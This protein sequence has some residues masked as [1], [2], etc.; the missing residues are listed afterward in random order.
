M[1]PRE[2]ANS[3]DQLADRWN[4]DTFSRSN[5]IEQ[6][7][8]AVAFAK[9]KRRALDIGCG[10]SGRIIDLLM[11]HG[12][13]AEGLDISPRMIRLAKQRHPNV[14]F[15]H[16]DIRGWNFAR[17]YDLI[18]GWD[19]I[20]HVPL[21]DYEAVLKKILHA[22]APGGVCIFTTAGVDAPTEKVDNFMGP[23]M[24]Y[25]A[26]GIPNT[27]KLLSEAGCSLRH[28]EYDQ[29][30]ELHMYIIAQRAD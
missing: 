10:S 12:F 5:G 6:H 28:L 25:S 1:T 23:P 3:Y 8:R 13:E 19:S 9:R 26:P 20:W 16:S 18:S 30:P 14:T 2:T 4:S 11:S 27:L 7:E 21:T 17:E 24:Y 15:H 22:L 29:Y